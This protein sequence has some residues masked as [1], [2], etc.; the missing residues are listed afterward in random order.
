MT[1]LSN[2]ISGF[3]PSQAPE[4]I[5]SNYPNFL[6]F[7]QYY[8]KW[9]EDSTQGA[10][11][12]NIRE[13]LPNLRNVDTIP[14]EFI[15]YLQADF[16]PGFPQTTLLD[17]RKLLKAATKFY[18]TK[19]SP[20][21]LEFLM[22]VLYGLESQIYYPKQNILRTSYGKWQ[23]PQ[24]LKLTLSPD[25]VG[26]NVASLVA[27]LGV[28]SK[29]NAT[30]V[31]ESVNQYIDP[32]LG[33]EVTELFLSSVQGV[34]QS[35]ENVNINV[36]NS[37]FTDKIIGSISDIIIN[38]KNQGLKYKG[39][40]YYSN[41]SINYPGDPVSIIGGYNTVD[42]I[43]AVAYV[44]NVSQGSVQSITVQEGGY[45]FQLNPNTIV[46]IV[47]QPGDN[48]T[49]SSAIVNGIDASNIEYVLF[50]TD[51]IEYKANAT[52]D[53]INY[54]FANVANSN[55]NTQL[56]EAWSFVNIG[57]APVSSIYLNNG[58]Y[59][60]QQVPSVS[61]RSIFN[62]DW[63]GDLWATYQL[64]PTTSNY[65]NWANNVGNVQDMGQVA[66][67]QVLNPGLNYD[68]ANDKIILNSEIGYGAAFSFTTYANGGIESV[69]V[70]HKGY[71]YP[72]PKP[73]V[74]IQS[75]T[76]SGATLKAYGFNDGYALDVSV[77]D[78]GKVQ[79]IRIDNYGFD[80]VDTPLVSLRN[81]DVT[82]VAISNSQ[83]IFAND[84]FYQGA[85]LNA[86]TFLANTDHYDRAN[87]ILRLYNYTGS[88]DLTS[89]LIGSNLNVTPLSIMIYGNG[90]AKANAQFFGGLIKYPGFW[91][92][93]DG[94]LSADQYL[95]G[96][97]IYQNYSYILKIEKDLVDYFP[98]IKEVLHP[99]GTL[100][101]GLRTITDNP[102]ITSGVISK[103]VQEY[104][105]SN[106]P[107]TI[108][109]PINSTI[110]TGNNTTFTGNANAGDLLVIDYQN[111]SR[112]QVKTI[113]SVNSDSNLTIDS[114]TTYFAFDR[115][116]TTTN[117]NVVIS[118]STT[119]N[120]I[121]N[122]IISTNI[123]GNSQT[124]IVVLVTGNNITLNTTFT[125]NTTNTGYIVYPLIDNVNYEIIRGL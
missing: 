28:G 81:Q 57:L 39:T 2:T 40:S 62:T 91:L 42:G 101:L 21:S 19:G 111:S 4:F 72:I 34:F 49:G 88:I 32:T 11:I 78:I 122:D 25:N 82:I 43:Q 95:Q 94:F 53:S 63:S 75:S 105:T 23:L 73:P 90:K 86:A 38:S 15:Q 67:I 33:R 54:D 64:D 79:S 35:G 115:L 110:V 109:I 113:V 37:T 6:L 51:S 123:N 50:N 44:E 100:L 58:G 18:L 16:L 56:G 107:G 117:S 1:T 61:L 9:L 45:G 12:Y 36:G 93:T 108:S 84:T 85:N 125:T 31:I 17:I 20:N 118:T 5:R 47:S 104:N 71:G 102:I 22:R 59:S 55:I 7:V 83:A 116:I 29:S 65:N 124:S 74:I 76:G 98:T 8:F 13:V 70:D 114:D 3:I 24:S 68:S 80:Y 52:L 103:N 96:P 112:L 30:C 14:D 66:A 121:A 48:G 10:A 97:K 69:T 41:G 77:S 27:R 119:S 89:N 92:G 60:Y 99:A 46:S 87:S 26:Y 120:L 106:T